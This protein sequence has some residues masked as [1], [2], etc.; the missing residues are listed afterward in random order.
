MSSSLQQVIDKKLLRIIRLFLNKNNQLFH[1]QKISAESKIPIGT[2]FRL[3]KKLTACGLVD[4]VSVGKIKLYKTNKKVAKEFQMLKTST[5][6][7]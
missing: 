1:L 5:V 6:K 3:I 7:K 4:I 2:T